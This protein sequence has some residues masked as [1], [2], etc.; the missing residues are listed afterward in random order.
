VIE[1]AAGGLC[2]PSK[3]LFL[4]QKP[5]SPKRFVSRFSIPITLMSAGALNGVHISDNKKAE[6]RRELPSAISFLE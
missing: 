4:D 2:N 5:D 3:T 1:V 6:G